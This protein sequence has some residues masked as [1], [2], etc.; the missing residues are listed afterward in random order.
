MKR[1]VGTRVDHA[2]GRLR[3]KTQATDAEPQ[4][5]MIADAPPTGSCRAMMASDGRAIVQDDERYEGGR[6]TRTADETRDG[7][8]KAMTSRSNAPRNPQRMSVT[9]S[10]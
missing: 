6:E 9:L 3:R 8:H 10:D 1:N 5:K 4:T 7:T 2:E